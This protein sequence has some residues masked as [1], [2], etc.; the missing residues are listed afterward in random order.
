MMSIEHF[1]DPA[2]TNYIHNPGV[3]AIYDQTWRI[4][5]LLSAYLGYDFRK[6]GRYEF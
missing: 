4:S 3:A 1:L 5:S 6:Y 2:P